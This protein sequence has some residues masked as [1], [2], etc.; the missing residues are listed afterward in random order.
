MALTVSDEEATTLYWA[1]ETL[2]VELGL[3]EDETPLFVRIARHVKELHGINAE[4]EAA[5]VRL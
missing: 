5:E 3:N 2:D 4:P 1:F